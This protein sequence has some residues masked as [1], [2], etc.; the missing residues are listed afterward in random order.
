MKERPILFSGPMV[1]AI[2][3]GRKTQTR[4]VIKPQ[5]ERVEYLHVGGGVEWPCCPTVD[6][7]MKA[8]HCPYGVPGDSLWVRETW[9]DRFQ[10]DWYIYR[11]DNNPEHAGVKWKSPIHMPRRAS[12]ITLPIVNV[13]A[14][15]LQDITHNDVF[16]EGCPIDTKASGC[17]AGEW[18][19]DRKM[20]AAAWFADLWNSINGKKHPWDSNPWVWVIE[21]DEAVIA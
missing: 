10:D 6:G 1:R 15:R 7:C 4:R 13:R 9:A 21:W 18:Q 20:K 12:R 8:M 3:E 5:P 19:T 16:A 11:A 14:E 2:I 17:V